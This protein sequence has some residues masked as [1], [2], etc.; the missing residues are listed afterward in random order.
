M[1]PLISWY[2]VLQLLGLI[3]IPIAHRLF[4]A[5]PSRGYA[6]AKPLALLLLGFIFWLL[7]SF[8]FLTNSSGAI[9][10]VLFGLAV[11]SAVLAWRDRA[12]LREFW[13]AQRGLVIG[14]ELIFLGF[15]IF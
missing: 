10:F 11:V 8:R 6:F 15:Y 2:I 13:K 1:P 3:G 4:G 12:A 7:G 9:V 5:L 14:T